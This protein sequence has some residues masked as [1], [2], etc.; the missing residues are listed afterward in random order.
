MNKHH[1]H[2]IMNKLQDDYNLVAPSFSKTRDRLWPEVKFLFDYAKKGEKILDLGCGNGRFSWYLKN[3]EYTGADFSSQ[4]IKEAVNRFPHHNFINCNA[5]SL[6]FSQ[7]HFDKVYS[8]AM[9]HQIPSHNYR[10]QALREIKRVLRPNGLAFIVV[11]NIY[12]NNK[13]FFITQ[14]LLNLFRFSRNPRDMIL[15]R[16]RYYYAFSQKK[17]SSLVKEEGF[18]IK[19]E[20]VINKGWRSNF[21]IIAKKN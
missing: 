13:K 19:E 17:L 5:L 11:W 3:A 6:P 7:N 15:K 1:A 8:I 4:M 10:R 12:K 2:K 18:T 16:D 14:Y 21:Y 9:L 20:G